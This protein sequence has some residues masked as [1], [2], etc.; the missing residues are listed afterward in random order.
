MTR[1][2]FA[3]LKKEGVIMKFLTCLFTIAV[4]LALFIFRRYLTESDSALVYFAVISLFA[5]V[6]FKLNRIEKLLMKLLKH[7][8]I[9][10]EEDDEEEDE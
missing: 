6:Y 7:E 3:L 4:A 2:L 5:Y 9:D 10:P 1:M 8:K